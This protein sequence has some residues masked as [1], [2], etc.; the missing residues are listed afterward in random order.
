[1]IVIAPVPNSISIDS[2]LR[3][4]A[5]I[6]PFIHSVSNVSPCLKSLYLSSSGWTTT[7]LSPNFVSGR[8]VPIS[9]G[10]NLK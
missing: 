10:P 1:V 3:R 5:V 6:F 2:S 4:V 9:K 7:Y 8:E